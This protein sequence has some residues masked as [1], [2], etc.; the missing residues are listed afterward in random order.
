VLIVGIWAVRLVLLSLCW[1]ASALLELFAFYRGNLEMRV[2]SSCFVR[3]N[4]PPSYFHRTS[5]G[6]TDNPTKYVLRV[7]SAVH[8]YVTSTVLNN[9]K[10]TVG[11]R[12]C[13]AV[14]FGIPLNEGLR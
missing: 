8:D 5:A 13:F 10:T 11:L 9:A 3:S 4:L 2:I 7:S 12:C 14:F 6:N 1:L